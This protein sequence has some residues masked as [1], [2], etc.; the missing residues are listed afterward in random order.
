MTDTL[1][2]LAARLQQLEDLEAI[3]TLK[4][5]YLRGCDLKQPEVVRDTLLPEGAV[6]AYE[7][8][9]AFED[10]DAF[11][12]VFAKMGCQPGVFD[13]HHATNSDI[14]FL[15]RDEAKG[16]W[17]LNFHSIVLFSRTVTHM[18]VEY[19]DRYVRRDGRWWI[20]ETRTKRPYCHIVKIGELGTPCTTSL[21][22]P[23]TAY[24]A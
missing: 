4:A 13:M 1:E 3:R 17:S 7:G 10:R 15:S 16:K 8:F 2:T 18:G 14:S 11:V 24:G 19:E 20:A 9:P 12:D 6:I 5:R 23:P 21:G 22:A